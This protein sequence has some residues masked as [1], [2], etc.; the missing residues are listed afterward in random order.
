V[1]TTLVESKMRNTDNRN[2][3]I[4]HPPPKRSTRD[5]QVRIACSILKRKQTD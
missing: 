5:V 1:Y 4:N 2:S 3:Q